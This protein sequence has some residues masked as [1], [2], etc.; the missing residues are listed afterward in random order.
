MRPSWRWAAVLLCLLVAGAAGAGAQT[1]TVRGQVFDQSGAVVAKAT[2]TATDSHGRETKT[3][4]AGD[5]SFSLAGLEPGA[6][7]IQ[8]S[9]PDLVQEPVAISVRAGT[10]TVRLELRVAATRQE[11][12]VQQDS[13]TGLSTDSSENASA[14]VLRGN[15]LNALA[16]DPEDLASDLQALAGPSAGPDGSSLYIDGFTGGELPPK[17]AIREIR[18]N[19]NPFSPE[20]DKLGYGRVEVLTKPGANNFHG[21]GYFNFGDSIWNSRNPYATQKAPFLLRE[22]GAS[23]EGPLGESASFFLAVDGAAID[24]GAIIN[25]STL[26][27]ATLAIVEPYTQVF[28]I[29]QERIRPSVRIDYQLTANDTVSMRYQFADADIRHSGVGGFDLTSMGVHNHGTD[30]SFQFSNVLALGTN[31][32][33]ETRFQYYRAQISNVSENA[34]PQLQVL[35]AFTGGG[36]QVGNSS[37]LLN[38]WELQNS[39]GIQR[40]KHMLRGGIRVRAATIDNTSPIDFGGTFT[41]A[42]RT[43]PELDATDQPVAGSN[44]Q[45]VLISI[46]SIEAYRR[47][48]LFQKQGLS[49]NQVRS[50]GGGAS[51]FTINAGNPRLAIDQADVGIFAGD[52]WRAKRNLTVDYGLRYEWQT[53]MHDARDFAPRLGLAWAPRFGQ[54]ASSPRTVIRAGFGIFYQRFDIVDVLTARRYNG[55]DQ[56]SF[57]VTNPDFFPSIPPIADL[58]RSG[59]QQAVEELSAKLRAPYLIESAAGVERQLPAHTT[60]ALTYVNSHGLHQF[61]TN[62]INAPLP[63]SW[64]P[65]VPGSGTYPMGVAN[66]V[67]QVQSGGL[68]NQNEVIANVNAKVNDAVSLFGSYLY[69]RAMSNTD[70]SSPP[71]NTDFNP[72]ITVQG[73][74]VGSFPANPWNLRGEYG[75][76]GTDVHHQVNVGGTIE[77]RGGLRVSPL[78]VADSGAPFNI[79]VGQ[80]LYGTTLFNGRPGIATDS[81]RPGVVR[82]RYGLLDPNPIAGEAV[83][84]RNSGRGPGITMLNL[85]LSEVFAFGPAAEGSVSAG[86]RRT[87]TGPFGGG[88]SQNIVKTGHRYSLAVSLGIR[89][90]LN[91]NNPGPIIGNITSPLFGRANQPYGAGSLGGTGF[92]ESADNRRLEFQTRLTF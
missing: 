54:G 27:P 15:D 29:P 19:Q 1:A 81:S 80:D 39:I 36:S 20:Y 75:P 59:S 44:G 74:G 55:V 7:R 73:F 68:Y 83:L 79:T 5:G 89:N 24:N 77:A 71:Q 47:T 88:Q 50:L 40:R 8:A 3:T 67:F 32:V 46:S 30:Q 87:E 72:A 37:N 43:G 57:V 33:N 56:Q 85:R 23:L 41:F 66:P 52:T 60:A 84:H 11:V 35:N 14:L 34:A 2:I 86:G 48:L 42:G 17:D 10:Q 18:I 38:T 65:L 92:S 13:G 91:H 70:Y 31:T 26:D 62:D 90:L 69:N 45:P 82:T 6:Y 63:G 16:D 49:A 28:T 21:G 61:L 22:Y 58:S 76:A 64:D 9:A 25:G 78:F 12:K 53:N 51:Q 4:S